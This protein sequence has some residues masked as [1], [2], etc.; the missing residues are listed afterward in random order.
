MKKS[1]L[2]SLLAMVVVASLLLTACGPTSVP[3]AV[4][5]PPTEVVAE[6][7]AVAAPPTVVA[8][9]PTDTAVP[10]ARKVV[11]LIWTQE[12]DTLN[13]LYSNM[14]FTSTT[15]ELWQCAA[16]V[17]DNQ[18]T[19]LPGLV[20]ELPTLTNGG[21][22]AD[23]KVITLKL[24]D[25]AVWSDGTPL[26]SEDF[27]FT[28]D[29]YVS[30]KNAVASTY[31]YSELE[32][33]E[34]PDA[35]TFVMTF[36]EAF[37]PWP[38]MWRG[39]LPEHVLKP[40]FDKDGTLDNAEWNKKPT[41][42]CGPYNFAEWESGSFARFVAN[43]KYWLGRPKID[44]IFFR[45]VPDDAS[46]VAALKTGDGDVG[47]FIAYSDMPSLK[48]AG[49]NIVPAFSLYNEGI[50]FCQGPKCHPA[51]KELNVRKA[52]ALATDRFS[53]CKDLLLGMTVPA[54]TD[55]DMTPWNDPSLQPWPF[56]PEQAKT[57][58]DEAGWKD[59][60]GDG[61]RDK[62]GVEL[63]LKYGTTTREIRK[64]TQAV[65]QQQLAAVGI[66]VDLFN[67]ESD[68]FFATYAEGGPTYTGAL[69]MFEY[70]TSPFQP[71]DPDTAAWLCDSIP[72]DDKPQGVNDSALCDKELDSMFLLQRTQVDLAAREETFHKITKYLL[73][74]ADW[75][76]LWQDPD[77]W[78][79]SSRLQNVKLSGF[80]PFYNV[81]EWDLTQ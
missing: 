23:G 63:V 24:R 70:S 42:G 73:D 37:A 41:V 12:F 3:T 20:T 35:T 14:W 58:L 26:T 33:V 50:F 62:D 34:A 39:I 74:N 4:V 28:Y 78:A 67:Y 59:S 38:I 56:D 36:K 7:T 53:L 8:A 48:E 25:D 72:T 2:F 79:V 11:T 43:D 13:P 69:D 49:V 6:A 60:N 44:E 40:V 21:L 71:P 9:V 30:P 57:L 75:L 65:L 52:I 10:E 51:L 17:F 81:M 64:D 68:Q 16:W 77:T 22:S 18:G 66:K 55:W 54:A 32:K 15:F 45:F 61:V 1:W 76:G 31:P 47:T 80:T 27:V 5:A 29:M 46:Q 19:I